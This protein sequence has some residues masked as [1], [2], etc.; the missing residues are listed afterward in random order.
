MTD[1]IAEMKALMASAIAEAK[2]MADSFCNLRGRLWW[3]T[4]EHEWHNWRKE[5][6]KTQDGQVVAYMYVRCCKH[7]GCEQFREQPI[8]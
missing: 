7:C 4:K 2:F 3:K 6:V 5:L 8:K 1:K